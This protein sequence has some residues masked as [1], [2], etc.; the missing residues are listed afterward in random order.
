MI[1]STKNI[2]S[3]KIVLN[4]LSGLRRIT[5]G[6]SKGTEGETS[7]ILQTRSVVFVAMLLNQQEIPPRK[8]CYQSSEIYC[9]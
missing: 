8:Y 9:L 5:V 4:F 1:S 7:G 3:N 6:T 2:F